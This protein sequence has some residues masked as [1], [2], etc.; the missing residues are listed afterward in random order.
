MSMSQI[1]HK[2]SPL[3]T[4]NSIL[5]DRRSLDIKMAHTV[6]VQSFKP[7]FLKIQGVF[8]GA[9]HIDIIHMWDFQTNWNLWDK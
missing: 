2:S 1:I 5:F 8:S 4:N 3:S 9:E 7:E 6:I